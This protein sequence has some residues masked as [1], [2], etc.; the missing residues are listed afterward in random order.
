MSKRTRLDAGGTVFELPSP[1]RGVVVFAALLVLLTALPPGAS[2]QETDNPPF[3][4]SAHFSPA[5]LPNTGGTVMITAHVIEDVAVA[6]VYAEVAGEVNAR[7]PMTYAGSDN[8]TG[9]FYAPPNPTEVPQYFYVQVYA[10]DT[11]GSLADFF[12]GEGS[13]AETTPFDEPPVV[14]N[15]SV[16]PTSLPHSG[17]NVS[18]AVSAWDLR[19][20]SNAYALISTGP[21]DIP[22][23]V[24]LEAVTSADRFHGTFAAPANTSSSPVTYFVHFIAQDDIGQEGSVEGSTFTVAAIPSPTGLLEVRPGERDFGT[25]KLGK[26]AQRKI[27]LR[28]LGRKG[29]LPVSGLLKTS[30]PPF[31][32]V[33]QTATGLSFTLKP[34]ETKTFK[35]GFAPTALGLATGKVNVLRSDNQQSGLGVSVTGRGR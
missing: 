21:G 18:L 13:V 16:T 15:P 14:A 1:I 5:G 31:S 29:T 11:N 22:D 6:D 12:A 20:I 32:V 8:W 2:A 33:G 23:H 17:G 4:N 27:V 3:I 10:T 34:G 24:Q 28:N 19:G 25:V 30:G 7:V 9:T 26:S 35:I